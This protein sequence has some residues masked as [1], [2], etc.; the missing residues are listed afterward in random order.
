MKPTGLDNKNDFLAFKK[1]RF[2]LFA[3]DFNHYIHEWS[4]ITG[5]Y[6]GSNKIEKVYEYNK[7]LVL[8]DTVNAL[9]GFAHK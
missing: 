2:S 1:E 4:V 3:L 9:K 7:L 8:E 6:I 5:K